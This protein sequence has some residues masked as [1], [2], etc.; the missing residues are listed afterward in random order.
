MTKQQYLEIY[1]KTP[2]WELLHMKKALQVLGGFLNTDEDNLR[3]EVILQVLK[4]KK[5]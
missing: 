3:L 2:R 1:S 4:T 5:G